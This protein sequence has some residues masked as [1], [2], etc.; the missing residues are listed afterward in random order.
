MNAK[1]TEI[2]AAKKAAG[3]DAY[4]WMQDDA[5]DCILW[6]SE[7]ASQDDSGRN[8]IARWSLT[9]AEAEALS[10]TGEVDEHN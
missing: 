5:G 3:D 6:P 2:L 7:A 10:E 8:A 9:K 4:L 1:I